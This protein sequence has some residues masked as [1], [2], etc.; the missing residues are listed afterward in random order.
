MPETRRAPWLR[1]SLQCGLLIFQSV[2]VPRSRAAAGIA[3][4]RQGEKVSLPV[5][6]RSAAGQA[7]SVTDI[8]GWI[9]RLQPPL[10]QS[11]LPVTAGHSV[12]LN[13]LEGRNLRCLA[14]APA[15]SLCDKGRQN[16]CPRTVIKA[17][18]A[19]ILTA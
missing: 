14:S 8:N 7:V 4:R 6:S 11:M 10:S 12:V 16:F 9:S 18:S 5:T 1:R 15:Q 2:R 13:G 3:Q 19:A 17:S